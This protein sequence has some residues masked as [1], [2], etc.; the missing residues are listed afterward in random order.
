MERNAKEALIVGLDKVDIELARVNHSREEFEE[1]L[2]ES[3]IGGD[4]CKAHQDG[5]EHLADRRGDLEAADAQ[6]VNAGLGGVVPFGEAEFKADDHFVELGFGKVLFVAD[7]NGEKLKGERVHIRLNGGR[8]R[9]V[10][11]EK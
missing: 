10:S 2:R 7:E 1:M 9:R 5:R 4:L 11:Q 8:E 6:G 3:V